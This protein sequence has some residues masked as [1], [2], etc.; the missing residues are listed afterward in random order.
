MSMEVT[1]VGF[2]DLRLEN[3]RSI[4]MASRLSF[5]L[6]WVEGF[7]VFRRAWISLKRDL[8]D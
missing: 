4:A 5:F 6:R 3:L 1:V 2:M 8:G 7:N